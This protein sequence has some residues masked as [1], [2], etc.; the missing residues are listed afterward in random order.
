MAR[1][2]KTGSVLN[3]QKWAAT[4]MVEAQNQSYFQ[5]YANAGGKNMNSLIY[6]NGSMS[7]GHIVNFPGVGT[8]TEP[9]I[10]GDT[11]A[12]GTGEKLRTFSSQLI[13]QRVRK[14][15]QTDTGFDRHAAGLE[16]YLDMNG[17]RGKMVEYFSKFYDQYIFDNLQGV[18]GRTTSSAADGRATHVIRLPF[19]S[20]SAAFGYDELNKLE[21]I[22]AEG[23]GFTNGP[24]RGALSAAEM[25][26]AM[27]K[28]NLM[29]DPAAFEL[30]KSNAG[31]QRVVQ[32]AD[33][34]GMNNKL[35]AP[36]IGDVGSIQITKMPRHRGAIRGNNNAIAYNAFSGA[37]D[38]VNS[39]N[40][41]SFKRD[42]V[43][44]EVC[45][46]RQYDGNGR[47]SGQEGFGVGTTERWSRCPL[48]GKQ[49]I[50]VGFSKMPEIRTERN[51]A[52]DLTQII[53][54]VWLGAQKTKW[55]PESRGDYDDAKQ[56]NQDWGVVCVDIQTAA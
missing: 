4:V 3:R 7:D 23:T 8:L 46:L 16:S 28:W 50:Q 53:M 1:P 34:R 15:A 5:P 47:W 22:V 6:R 24:N 39:N 25:N 13:A 17:I 9:V 45:G 30:L 41:G 27:G 29:L 11:T 35:L 44:T 36:V 2:I 51:E 48:V 52:D 42:Q 21:R 55:D 49:A 32:S 37:N 43:V 31:F 18:A 54:E 10:L 40:T 38:T 14:T 20:S 56:T 19:V 33:S 26:G 12:I